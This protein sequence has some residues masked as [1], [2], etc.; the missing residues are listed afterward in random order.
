MA[1]PAS[2]SY[3]NIG[4][5][6]TLTPSDTVFFVA[7]TTNNPRGYDYCYLYTL[8]TGNITFIDTNGATRLL[9][10]VPAHFIVPIPALRVNATATTATMLALIPK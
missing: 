3:A 9:S 10:S 6:L 8:T 2:L 7:D 1:K 4:E 5:C